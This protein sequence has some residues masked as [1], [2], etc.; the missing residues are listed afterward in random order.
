MRG[1]NVALEQSAWRKWSSGH[2]SD[3]NAAEDTRLLASRS[4]VTGADVLG[5]EQSES[6][7]ATNE[8]ID[9]VLR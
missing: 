7:E 9:S 2:D 1:K 5:S 6:P 4:Q 8:G 3:W